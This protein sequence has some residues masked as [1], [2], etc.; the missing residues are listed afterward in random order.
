MCNQEPFGKGFI[1]AYL[2]GP[3]EELE[4]LLGCS[5]RAIVM[6]GVMRMYKEEILRAGPKEVEFDGTSARHDEPP[7]R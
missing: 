2:E 1:P 4:K 6:S 7:K 3:L 5:G